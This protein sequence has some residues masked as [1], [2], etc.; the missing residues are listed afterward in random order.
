MTFSSGVSVGSTNSKVANQASLTLNFG[1]FQ[2]PVQGELVVAV[3]AV[4]NNQTT[5]GDEGAVTG[6]TDNFGNTWQKGAEFTNGQ[7]AVQAGAT[8]AIWFS[9]WTNPVAGSPTAGTITVSFSNATS[10]DASA[11]TVWRFQASDATKTAVVVEATATLASDNT[12]NSGSL[13]A[14]TA[15]IECLRVRGMAFEQD[16]VNAGISPT[17][18]WSAMDTNGTTGGTAA[19]NMSVLGEF[20]ITSTATGAASNPT[21]SGVLGDWASV[22]VALKEALPSRPRSFGVL[23]GA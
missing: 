13:D 7:G 5:D 14:T 17:L 18:F 6:L 16:I 21:G 23:I 4:D 10:R 22:Y 15:S 1:I 3:I 12:A 19:T 2:C 11:I 9:K 8:C 20:I